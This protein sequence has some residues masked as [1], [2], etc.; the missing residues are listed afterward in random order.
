ME[1]DRCVR[2]EKYFPIDLAQI[3]IPIDVLNL[4]ENGNYN[5]NLV[6][7]NKIQKRFL[8]VKGVVISEWQG[9]VFNASL[10]FV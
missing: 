8:R 5:P 9:L 4:S 6:W 10:L 7:I 2:K 1:Y 3:R